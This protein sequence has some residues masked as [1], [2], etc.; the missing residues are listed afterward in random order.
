MLAAAAFGTL[1]DSEKGRPIVSEDLRLA[2]GRLAVDPVSG[3]VRKVAVR[4]WGKPIVIAR[5]KG[6]RQ[7]KVK[8][9]NGKVPAATSRN[10]FDL[11]ALR[12][13][14]AN[15]NGDAASVAP[16]LSEAG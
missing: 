1:A 16:E 3:K 4:L 2:D 9:Q 10:S 8:R 13:Q 14:M 7:P 12:N 5:Q 6:K 11:A 15:P